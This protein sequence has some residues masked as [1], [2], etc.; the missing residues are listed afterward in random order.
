M[1]DHDLLIKRL[2][3]DMQPVK[4]LRATRWRVI[5]WLALAL[6]CGIAASFLVPRTLTDW[7]EPGALRALIQ[8]VLAFMLSLLAVGSALNMSIPGRR[9]ISGKVLITLALVWLG[10]SL[11]SMPGAMSEGHDPSNTRCF[12]FLLVVSTPMMVLII[13]TLRR[14]RAHRP[15]QSLAMAG[16]GVACLAVSLLA[17]CH[18]VHLQPLDFLL[19]LAGVAV[20]VSVTVLFGRRWVKWD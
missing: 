14:S 17:F 18:P 11:S 15:L 12:S 5:T 3:D 16:L 4:P 8:S 10:L 19:H 1:S 9:G 7:S 20:V 6:P 13:A 2:S